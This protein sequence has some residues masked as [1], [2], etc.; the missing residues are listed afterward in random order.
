MI[1][2][3]NDKLLEIVEDVQLCRKHFAKL[4]RFAAG[5]PGNYRPDQSA[6]LINLDF[7][8]VQTVM[9]DK[10][11]AHIGIGEAEE[12]TRLWSCSAGCILSTA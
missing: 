4:M 3:P 1:V 11:I 7:A 8:D 5:C 10:G 12:M 2:I 6:V 9:T